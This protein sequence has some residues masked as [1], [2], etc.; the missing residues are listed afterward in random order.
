MKTLK[1]K[2]SNEKKN[3]SKCIISAF[4]CGNDR[5]AVCTSSKMNH[6]GLTRSW[7]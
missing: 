6:P 3:P 2:V 4:L 5:M 1:H 7:L